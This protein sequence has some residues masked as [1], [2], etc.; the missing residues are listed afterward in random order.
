MLKIEV[1]RAKKRLQNTQSRREKQHQSNVQLSGR[2][3]P[4]GRAG[5][6]NYGP[7]DDGTSLH[8]CGRIH[9]NTDFLALRSS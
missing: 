3:T 2:L 4:Q 8:Y 9:E 6:K 5:T 7:P 1:Y